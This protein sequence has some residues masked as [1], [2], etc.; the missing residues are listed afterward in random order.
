ME[1]EEDNTTTNPAVL[2]GVQDEHS[3]QASQNALPGTM[4]RVQFTLSVDQPNAAFNQVVK[5]P[6]LEPSVEPHRRSWYAAR[7]SRDDEHMVLADDEG[8]NKELPRRGRTSGS[9]TTRDKLLKDAESNSKDYD[10]WNFQHHDALSDNLGELEPQQQ[11]DVDMHSIPTTASS[12]SAPTRTN[13]SLIAQEF[14]YDSSADTDDEDSDVD[15]PAVTPQ[16]DEVSREPL[17]PLSKAVKRV[18]PEAVAPSNSNPLH[19]TRANIRFGHPA[20]AVGTQSTSGSLSSGPDAV[21]GALNP[22]VMRSTGAQHSRNSA[23]AGIKPECTNCGATHTPL[24]RRGLNDELNCNRCGLYYKVHK[25]PRPKSMRS[26]PSRVEG[27]TQV[28][29][30]RE[31][32]ND[33]AQCR[34][35]QTTVTPLWRKDEEGNTVCNACGLYY[36]LHG[37]VRPISMKSDVIRRRS[38]HPTASPGTS[39]RASASP[40]SASSGAR[41]RRASFSAE[42]FP[43]VAPD[44]TTQMRHDYPELFDSWSPHASK[45]RRMSTDSESG[46]P[47][48]AM[49]YSPYNEGYSIS[50]F[51]AASRSR[52]TSMESP[53]PFYISPSSLNSDPTLGASGNTFWHPPTMPQGDNSLHAIHPPMLL[54]TADDSPMSYAYQPTQH[55]EE[56]FSSFLHPPMAIPDGNTFWHPPMMPLGDNSPHAIHPAML[57]PT[58]DDSPMDY[59]HQPMHQS[60]EEL[61]SSFLHPPMAIPDGNT[62][63]HPPMMPLGDN[64][65]HALHP[66]MLLPTI[67]DSPMSYAY[68]PTQHEEELFSAFLHPPM[69]IPDGNTFWHPPMV[70]LG[71]NSPHAIHPPMLPP[72]TDDSP[73]DYLHQPM[74]HDE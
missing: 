64:S 29:R 67:D 70:P 46:P 5:K 60:I 68:Q 61:F 31:A 65:P 48:S 39:R 33:T 11:Q 35:C 20:L 37:S 47:S 52:R 7:A 13:T 3:C 54:P 42:A 16:L 12:T 63:W 2:E 1:P 49:S 59:L 34:N 71:D 41:S 30:R 27:R 10:S 51:P 22:A 56:S 57:P 14:G 73:M 62:F 74:Q 53:S 4:G 23:L 8:K 26:T 69:A 24:W 9:S 18:L 40:A 17:S 50:P 45:R 72:T 38:R 25:R 6:S 43:T 28:R 32:S 19:D 21:A 44:F 36:K 55:E 66:P 58:T 15:M